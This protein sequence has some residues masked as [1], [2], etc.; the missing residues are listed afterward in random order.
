MTGLL[1]ERVAI[2]TGGGVNIGRAVAR[3]FAAEGARV[4]VSGRREELLEETVALIETEG[5]AAMAV[6]GDVTSLADMERVAARTVERFGTIDSLAALAGGGHVDEEIDRIDAG[7]W[8]QV[9]QQNIV[10]TFHATRA[11]L[12]TMRAKNYGTIVTCAGGGALFPTPGTC[13]TD[14]ATAKAGICRFTDQLAVELMDTGIRVN[15]MLPGLTW[16]EEKLAEVAAEEARTGKPHP[17]REHNRPPEESAEL[18]AWLASEESSP[19]FG[20]TILT[21]EDWWR[22]PD[23]VHL[24]H[25]SYHRSC[26]RRVEPVLE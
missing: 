4:V 24:V 11:V 5:G 23:K 15:C 2:V 25:H 1:S 16:P 13:A 20:R 10:G 7:W 18:A 22:D 14:Y 6:P 21:T 12:P 8:V 26:L 17:D 19:L 9:I 3:R